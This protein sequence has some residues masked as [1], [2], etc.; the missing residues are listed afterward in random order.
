LGDETTL[1]EVLG[2][3]S[4]RYIEDTQFF[5]ISATHADPE[6][7]QKLTDTAAQVFIAENI[8]RQQAE[9]EQ[10]QAQQNPVKEMERQQSA[11]LQQSLQ[12]E[13]DYSP[14][15]LRSCRRRSPS[16]RAIRPP[17]RWISVS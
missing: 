4:T 9:Q 1:E 16:W 17:K 3:I 7:A 5:K 2:A 11:G 8:A 15:R 13:L 6:K 14:S 10:I 12:D